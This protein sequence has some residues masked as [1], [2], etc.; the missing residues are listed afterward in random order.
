MSNNVHG[1]SF[2]LAP[3]SQLGALIGT[4]VSRRAFGPYIVRPFRSGLWRGR[5]AG[6]ICEERRR[7][8]GYGGKSASN[9]NPGSR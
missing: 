4:R 7:L 8:F 1:N 5:M 3:T 6:S 9:L 2:G